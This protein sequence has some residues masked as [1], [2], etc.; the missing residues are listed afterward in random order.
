MAGLY[1]RAS[2]SPSHVHGPGQK[3]AGGGYVGKR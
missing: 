1:R 3:R 2:Y